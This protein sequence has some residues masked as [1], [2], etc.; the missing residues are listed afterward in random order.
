MTSGVQNQN[1]LLGYPET[2]LK[3]PLHENV[4]P[5]T[6]GRGNPNVP[7][8]LS[9]PSPPKKPIDRCPCSHNLR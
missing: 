5:S 1:F 9:L 7:D 2:G 3:L 8:D 4:H 6:G